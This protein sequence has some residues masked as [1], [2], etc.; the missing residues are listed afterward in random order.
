MMADALIKYETIDASQIDDI[1]NGKEP[2]PPAD[3]SD[4]EPGAGA[5]SREKKESASPDT[6]LGGPAGEH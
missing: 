5:S 4:Q 2:R 6:P 3:W 1:M